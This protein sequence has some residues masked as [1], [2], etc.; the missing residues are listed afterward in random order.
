MSDVVAVYEQHPATLRDIWILS[1]DHSRKTFLVTAF[2]ERA[3]R[4]SPD[5]R[6][7]AYRSD[8][9]GEFEL[10][11][12]AFPALGRKLRLTVNGAFSDLQN[13]T[14]ATRW[15]SD[16]REILYYSPDGRTLM[17]VPVTLGAEL[18]AG[19]PV[20]LFKLPPEVEQVAPS[21]D[22]QRFYAIVANQ[23]FS[24]GLIR[25]VR[26]WTEGLDEAR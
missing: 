23:T 9:S 2:Q 8:E 22:G 14:L 6:W 19:V 25:L 12:Q 7:I 5:G 10:Y 1:P 3:P 24:R 4:F 21:P 18:T 11:A 17:S 13:D 20:P 15:R 26:N 16:G